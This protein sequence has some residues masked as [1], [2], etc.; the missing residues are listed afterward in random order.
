MSYNECDDEDCEGLKYSYV[1]QNILS[2]YGFVEQ[3]PRRW[4]LGP[5]DSGE[6]YFAEVDIDET[7]GEVV[8]N[9]PFEKRPDLDDLQWL[10]SELRRLRKLDD[11]VAKGVATLDSEHERN[12][13]S[14]YHRGYKEVLALAIA[15][16]EDDTVEDDSNEN[17][18]YDP[19]VDPKGPAI[20]GL[21]VEVCPYNPVN[22]D[23]DTYEETESQYQEI[24]FTYNINDD[25]TCLMLSGWYQTCTNFRPH[26]H[27]AFV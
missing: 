14:E 9:W 18:E 24:S 17:E 20:E 22:R 1:T 5:R 27:E 8:L 15:Y 23:Y 16:R 7:T 19:L 4:K 13:I 6:L 12:V 3:Y 2:D 26:Y 11:E 10:R 21:N 25:N